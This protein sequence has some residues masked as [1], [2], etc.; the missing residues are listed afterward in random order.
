MEH[1]MRTGRTTIQTQGLVDQERLKTAVVLLREAGET[2]LTRVQ[3]SRGLGAASLRT[4]D[5][6]LALLEDQGARLERR[7]EGRPPVLVFTLKRGPS[8]DEHITH[9]ARLA[10]RLAALSLAQSGTLMWQDKLEAIEAL[11]AG[12]MSAKDR[13]LFD[14]LQKAVQVH[15]GVDDPIESQDVIEPILQALEGPREME[16]D[17]QSAGA[18][19]A[20]LLTVVPYALT[21]DL[22]S[23]GA[24]LLVWD[25][26]RRKPL[27]LR[28]SR[29]NRAKALARPGVIPC[30]DVLARAAKYQIGGWMSDDA[31]FTIKARI[32]GAHWVQAFKEAPPA[33]PAFQARPEKGGGTMVV[34]F[35]ANHEF[36]AMRWLLQ[37]G[38]AITVLEPAW[39]KDKVIQQLEAALAGNRKA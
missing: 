10:L 25:P 32:T 4:V 38:G 18:R 24:F 6:A 22:Y 31:P 23:G 35:M 16:I 19:E 30:P 20:S 15:G 7:R 37:F 12:H 13:R 8:W 14:T 9:Q 2:G 5:R 26:R 29:I 3:L 39:L 28:L 1:D 33:L 36:G 27:H 11:A 21:H 34:A 17:Y